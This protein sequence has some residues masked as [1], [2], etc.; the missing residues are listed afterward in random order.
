M[1]QHLPLREYALSQNWEIYRE[2]V[3]QCPATDLV[4]RTAWRKLLDE[5]ARKR[6]DLLLVWRMD[7]AFRSVLYA[8]NTLERLKTWRAN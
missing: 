7:R 1:P 4:N 2:Y 6:F 8:A 5:A 3:D